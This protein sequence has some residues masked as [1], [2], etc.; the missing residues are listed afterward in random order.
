MLL[1]PG[2]QGERLNWHKHLVVEMRVVVGSQVHGV[3]SGD[4]SH[5]QLFGLLI[6]LFGGV[7]TSCFMTN[8]QQFSLICKS[9]LNV[10]L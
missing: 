4:Y 7:D 8:M 10:L 1:W 9:S 5:F 6:R 3:T 2:G